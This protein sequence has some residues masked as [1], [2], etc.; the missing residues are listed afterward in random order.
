MKHS[1]LDFLALFGV[2]GAHPGGLKLTKAILA[3]ENLDE[4][5]SVLDVGCGTGQT[6]AYIQEQYQCTVTSLDSNKIMVDKARQR[7]LSL[8]LPVEVIEGSAEALPF[9]ESVFDMV[10][11]ESVASFT[12]ASLTIPAFKRMLKSDGVLIVVEM[13]LE[14]PLIEKEMKPIVDFYGVHQLL[15]ESQWYD[16]FKRVGF[17][18]IDIQKVTLGDG[19]EDLENAPDFSVSENIDD[20]YFEI[21]E[22]H[23]HLTK[24]YK[25]ILGFRI[26]KCY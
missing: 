24:F 10:L 25:D 12:D 14:K 26:F 4:K 1:Y 23:E 8:Q 21:L 2:G 3:T 7:F 11:S 5:K 22:K 19:G 20:A 9:N 18:H 16:R 15:T 6:S 13:V 17:T